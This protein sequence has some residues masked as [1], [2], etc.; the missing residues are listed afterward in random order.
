MSLRGIFNFLVHNISS[1]EELVSYIKTQWPS[2]WKWIH[3][4][5]IHCFSKPMLLTIT[6]KLRHSVYWTAVSLLRTLVDDHKY[7]DVGD[8]HDHHEALGWRRCE[9]LAFM[10]STVLDRFVSAPKPGWLDQVIAAAGNGPVAVAPVI[11]ERFRANIS[12]PA[13]GYPYFPALHQDLLIVIGFSTQT[14]SAKCYA[15]WSQHSVTMVTKVMLRLASTAY[16]DVPDAFISQCLAFCA[17]YICMSFSDS[18]DAC[19]WVVQAIDAQ[20]ILALLKST[21]YFQH[22]SALQSLCSD[23]LG[24][25]L[26]QYSVY[27]SVLRATARSLK[28][29]KRLGLDAQITETDSFQ[30]AWKML[31]EIVTERLLIKAHYDTEPSLLAICDDP[32]VQ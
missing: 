21:R 10:A 28:K 8:N 18:E 29:V 15:L 26:P 2:I 25:I 12:E 11:L 14:T 3:F 5:L 23:I 16:P 22:E 31:N 24:D 6:V 13:L 19:T 32:Q 30:D 1:N 4:L 17:M 7:R 27:R 9:V 20:L